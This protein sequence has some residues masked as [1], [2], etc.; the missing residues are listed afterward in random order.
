MRPLDR[1]VEPAFQL[2]IEAR[3]GGQ[4]ALSAT[5][6][7]TVTV[8]DANDHAPTFPEPA[9]SVE[10][11]ED[12]PA[13]TLLLQLQAHDPDAGA[14]GHVTYYLGAGAAGAFLLEPSS[15]ELRTATAL[16]REQCP[17]Y[18]FTVNA[19]DAAAAGP[20]STTVPVTVTVR[21][22][23][24]HAP[25][26]PTSPLRLRLP[27]P[28]PS[29]STPTLPLATLR[30]EDR[31]AGANASILYRLAG[32]PPPG[33]T[34]DSYTGEIRVARSPVT[35]G[36][37][38]RVL[39]I[40]ATDLGRPARSAT[41]VVIVGLQGEPERGPRFPRASSE[42]VLRE[43]APPGA[44]QTHL[45]VWQPWVGWGYALKRVPSA[46]SPELTVQLVLSSLQ[47][48]PL[49]PPRLS[50]RGA[51]VDPSPTASSAGTSEGRSPSSPVQVGKGRSRGLREG[52]PPG[53]TPSGPQEPLVG[54][55]RP[56]SK[57]PQGGR[58][59]GEQGAWH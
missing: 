6:L 33:T 37:R 10:V 8:L 51:R 4:P 47:E 46:L 54:E 15:G 39:F 5:L 36:P 50:T 38:D 58:L 32:T 57:G 48:L 1:E 43:N 19:V 45:S 12:A 21:D 23:N 56:L 18:A 7:V 26:F 28:G 16:D 34:V 42:A 49:S 3:D 40:V 27:R 41:G 30:A 31:D 59:Q 14:N 55:G 17:S 25:T 53:G 9:Y 29:L 2:K 13:G 52:Q 35:L 24:D 11:P 22:V 44:S 20:L